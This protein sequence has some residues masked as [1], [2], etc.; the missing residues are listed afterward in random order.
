[1]LLDQDAV[2]APRVGD[3]R[4]ALDA[5][6]TLLRRAVGTRADALIEER[7]KPIAE[8][9]S[10]LFKRTAALFASHGAAPFL[11]H[12]FDLWAR[13]VLTLDTMVDRG[14]AY[15]AQRQAGSPPALAYDY[16]IVVDGRDLARPCCYML[17]AIKPPAGVE[18]HVWKRP[19]V[20]IDPRAGHGAGIGGSKS[21]SQVGVALADGHPVY[22]IAFR[23]E[24][25]P[26]QTLADVA[27]AEA[28]FIETV[29][30]RHPHAAEPILVGNCQGGWASLLV[31]ATHPG[32]TGP[33]VVN[34]APVATWSGTPG[35]GASMRYGGGAPGGAALAM[36]L[37][38]FGGG[39]FD[40]AHLVQNFEGLNPGR[41]FFRKHYDL[42]A[43]PLA[44]RA[45]FLE[46]ER[47]WSSFYFMTEAEIRW[48]VEQLFIGNRLARNE[49]QLER[50]RH[51]DLKNIT[52]PVIVFASWGDVI[53]PPEQALR[54]I[55]DT[56]ADEHEI[57][58]RGQR[59]VYMI[60]EKVGHLGIFV[61]SSVAK[62]EH[63]Q[64]AS[65]LKTIEAL[66]P[67]LYEMRIENWEG[68]GD[69]ARFTVSLSERRLTDLAELCNGGL[70]AEET[71][72][73]EEAF[74]AVARSS[75]LAADLYDIA[76]RPVV[77][78]MISPVA[79]HAAREAHPLRTQR[80]LLS[81][82][83]PVLAASLAPWTTPAAALA[84]EF[85]ANPVR[86]LERIWADAT[87]QVWDLARDVG[88]AWR[89]AAFLWVYASPA[90]RAFGK[91]HAFTRTKKDPAELGR[92]PTVR[93][94]LRNIARGGH[95]EGVV[96]MLI[97]LADA[98]GSVRRDRLERA[99]HLLAHE[100]PFADLTAQARADLIHEQNI[101]AE[102]AREAAIE[103]LPL[104]LRDAA[105]QDAALAQVLAV[106]GPE[107]EMEPSTAAMMERFRAALTGDAVAA[108]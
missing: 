28:L 56:Y 1:M 87:H 14:D 60:H 38:D 97:L 61:S 36:A 69:S 64:L 44:E 102:Y 16:E 42:F 35:R 83:N 84:A 41:T 81:R 59:L 29:R 5:Q 93:A 18:T 13:A 74:A 76:A 48:I 95:A 11:R 25:S 89:E 101:I 26:S 78:P 104:L 63:T 62:K 105:L 80:A 67:G 100:A 106:A 82:R 79:A 55:V 15:F 27:R 96:R 31:A 94:A 9:N 103:T 43:D 17:L 20:I 8:L 4:K 52:A 40:G 107:N 6:S 86:D 46:F 68:E 3:L 19:Y 65:T 22:F 85:A 66:A 33:V 30:E 2:A 12:G 77:R 51:V 91:S 90:M 47:W 108:Q 70:S 54:W 75:E 10:E 53:T 71:R 98:R 45:R 88:A 73:E 57:K 49:A 32:L 72:A 21:D 99:A 50:G 24:P 7:L 92:L 34:G 23:P 58:I 39:Y 37:S